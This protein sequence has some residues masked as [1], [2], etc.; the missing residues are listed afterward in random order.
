M[1]EYIKRQL[2][3]MESLE[4]KAIL[5]DLLNHLFFELHELSEEKYAALELRIR[6]ELPQKPEQFAV[7]TTVWEQVKIDAQHPFL[8]AM[9]AEDAQLQEEHPG[10]D[11]Q[12]A[13]SKDGEYKIGL[14]FL[15]ADYSLC[16]ALSADSARFFLGSLTNGQTSC[17]V[18]FQIRRAEKYMALIEKMYHLFVNNGIPWQTLNIPYLNKFFEIYLIGDE[19]IDLPEGYLR[20]TLDLER[21]QPFVRYGLAPVWNVAQYQV[22]AN[23][24]PM[25]VLDALNY[26]YRFA[27][28]KLGLEHGYLA[29]SD[30]INILSARREGNE[31]VVVSSE[32]QNLRWDVFAIMKQ[33]ETKTDEFPYPLLSNQSKSDFAGRLAAASG[34][35]V[36]TKGE[37]IRVFQSFELGNYLRFR[38]CQISEDICAGEESYDMDPFLLDEIRHPKVRRVLTLQFEAVREKWFLNRDI[39][40]FLVSRAQQMFPEYRCEGA[41]I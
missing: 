17:P 37:L 2:D 31:L 40:S 9:A 8:R 14:C 6:D 24:F 3:Q 5:K 11:I 19:N 29:D 41:L 32:E 33:R 30:N 23:D 22:K 28:D 15:E 7:Y 34:V 20:F 10:R 4:D 21:Y 39:M 26:E 25:P 13:L 27:L 36:K 12:E 38:D 16:A 18:R 1:R 35:T